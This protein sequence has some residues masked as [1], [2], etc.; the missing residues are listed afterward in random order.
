MGLNSRAMFNA[1]TSLAAA[2][3]QFDF[4]TGHEPKGAPSATGLT[5]A[6]WLGDIRP[7]QSSGQASVSMRVEFQCRIFTSMLQEPQDGIDPRIMDAVDSFLAAI[8]GN[9]D[10]DLSDGRYVDVLGSD[11]DSLR[12]IPGYL[13]QDRKL[14]RIMEVFVPVLVNDVYA[15]VA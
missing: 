6:V 4:V 1:L 8:I 12:A 7:I 2:T 5:C 3:G 14:F 10:L 11:G 15:E 9:F 13:E